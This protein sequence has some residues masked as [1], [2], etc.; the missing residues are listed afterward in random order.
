[1]GVPTNQE[2]RSKITLYFSG[3]LAARPKNLRV[4]SMLPKNYRRLDAA[5]TW[6]GGGVPWTD[7]SKSLALQGT[8]LRRPLVLVQAQR[9]LQ[10]AASQ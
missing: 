1:M 6:H 9:Q 4:F 8:T 5:W 3:F 2:F 7:T 10:N